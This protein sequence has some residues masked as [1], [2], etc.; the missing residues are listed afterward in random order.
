MRKLKLNSKNKNKFKILTLVKS[1]YIFGEYSA[2]NYCIF[3]AQYIIVPSVIEITI[4][5]L[6]IFK[7]SY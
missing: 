1:C 2:A 5:R 6:T 3:V 7:D 4:V